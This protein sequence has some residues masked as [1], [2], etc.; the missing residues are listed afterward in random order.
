M[1][2]QRPSNS[3]AAQRSSKGAQTRQGLYQ[4]FRGPFCAFSRVNVKTPTLSF[5][6]LFL[7]LQCSE[8]FPRYFVF[9]RCSWGVKP[10]IGLRLPSG[11]KNGSDIPGIFATMHPCVEQT[12]LLIIWA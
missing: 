4:G 7:D 12:I 10:C 2:L 11:L 5:S 6:V 3:D 8:N 1:M 9:L